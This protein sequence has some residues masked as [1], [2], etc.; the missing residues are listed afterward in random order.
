MFGCVRVCPLSPPPPPS[1]M[2]EEDNVEEKYERENRER[3][4]R[5]VR[6]RF[7][8][9]VSYP[10]VVLPEN[11]QAEKRTILGGL[12]WLCIPLR[13]QGGI[14]LLPPEIALKSLTFI[15]NDD[16]TGTLEEKI[17]VWKKERIAFRK[18]IAEGRYIEIE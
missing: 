11:S 10:P 14:S 9:R 17:H 5:R 4:E 15:F 2:S 7:L 16:N 13:S 18:A 6:R 12:F 3:F 1:A 8:N